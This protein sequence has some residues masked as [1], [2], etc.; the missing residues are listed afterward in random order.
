M[1]RLLLFLA[2]ALA[3]L[4]AEAAFNWWIDPFGGIWKQS[5]LH[6]AE[7]SSPPCL[8]SQ[9]LIGIDYIPFK[10]A[11]A[12]ERRARILVFGSSRVLKIA[13]RPGERAFANLGMPGTGPATILSVLHDLP[14]RPATLYVGVE[15]FWFNPTYVE[16]NLRPGFGWYARYLLSRETFRGS[17]DLVRQA[18]YVLT[19]RW[20]RERLG[21]RCVIGR[22]FPS[23]AWAVDGSRVWSWELD[24]KRFPRFHPP[25][26]T[27]DL[28]Q[29]RNGYYANWTRF[30]EQR[31]HTLDAA[32][33]LAQRRGWRVVGF[34]PPEPTRYLRLLD[35]D[36]RV[37][38]YWHEFLRRMPV[39]FRR[40]GF[41]WID[42][43]DARRVPCSDGEFPDAFHSDA[44]CS[45][46]LRARLDAA[47]RAR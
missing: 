8:V 34:P 32:L 46:R 17:V 18:R 10:E 19:E 21:A 12:R 22:T 9:E 14:R 41:T 30:D 37:A 7:A 28:A 43:S 3:L 42:L 38:P 16:A 27:T 29:V 1:R 39:L 5:V 36:P 4:G 2:V 45:A 11:I 33:A 20:R 31:L 6:D 47:A 40:H 24:P 26:F 44:R 13:S 15:A 23:I 25:P 35:T